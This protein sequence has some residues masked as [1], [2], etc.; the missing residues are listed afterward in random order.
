MQEIRII[1]DEE[2]IRTLV[3]E[4]IAEAL[5]RSGEADIGV[6]SAV[7]Q[8]VKEFIYA[9]KEE[10]IERCVARATAELVKKGLPKLLEQGV[11]K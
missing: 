1:V 11:G 8:G 4:K 3:T 6:R 2:E 7:Q 10:I 5:R 9:H